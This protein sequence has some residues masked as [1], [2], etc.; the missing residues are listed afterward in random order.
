MIDII[1]Y[2]CSQLLP[3]CRH[4][5]HGPLLTKVSSCSYVIVHEDC[6]GL[7]FEGL[8][9]GNSATQDEGVDVMC[10]LVCVDRLQIHNLHMNINIMNTLIRIRI[11]FLLLYLLL[12]LI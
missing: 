12:H 1:Y 7:V 9:A 2:T 10:A 4:F 5:S 6:R 3:W 8:D 11:R